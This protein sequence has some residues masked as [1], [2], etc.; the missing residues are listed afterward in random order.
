[1]K[2]NPH[3]PADEI[4]EREPFNLDGLNNYAVKQE[5][6]SKLLDSDSDG[7]LLASARARGLLPSL[8]AGRAAFDAVFSECNAFARHISPHLGEVLDDLPISLL[9][10]DTLLTGSLKDVRQG[11]HIRWRCAGIKGK[12]RLSLWCEHLLLNAIKP[13]G[14]PRESLLI[15]KDL[16]LTLPPLE[17]ASERLADLLELY[18]EGLCLPLHFF[19]QT[20]WLFLSEGLSKAEERWNGTDH[21][22]SP[23]ESSDPSLSLCFSGEN[24][25]DSEFQELAH[26][27]YGPLQDISIIKKTV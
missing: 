10:Q 20:S 7:G 12:D 1:M 21:S 26:R 4:E 16:T 8:A 2:V 3:D 9:V 13:A 22:H 15:C 6:T 11:T 24:V 27:I 17:D 25:L 5:L 18:R 19:P 23:A 14:Y